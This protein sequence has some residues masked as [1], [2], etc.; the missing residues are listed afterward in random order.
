MIGANGLDHAMNWWR[1]DERGRLRVPSWEPSFPC[2]DPFSWTLSP[3]CD[4]C[5]GGPWTGRGRRRT[6]R[7][8]AFLACAG[9]EGGGRLDESLT[10]GSLGVR[11]KRTNSPVGR[12]G[13]VRVVEPSLMS[14]P[15]SSKD[16]G[17]E[18]GREHRYQ[19]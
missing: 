8:C 15:S 6:R 9:G 3:S 7:T 10:R 2:G 18:G 4:V 19:R 16:V 17:D 11:R 1:A 12:I 5:G 14:S 13:V